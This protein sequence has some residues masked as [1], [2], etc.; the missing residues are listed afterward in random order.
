[1]TRR[2]TDPLPKARNAYSC[3]PPVGMNDP[4]E[5]FCYVDDLL[6]IHKYLTRKVKERGILDNAHHLDILVWRTETVLQEYFNADYLEC[7]D[8]DKGDKEH[9]HY[10]EAHQ[11][12]VEIF[13]S[14]WGVLPSKEIDDYR[15][16]KNM[17]VSL[18]SDFV[19]EAI[20]GLQQHEPSE[21]DFSLGVRPDTHTTSKNEPTYPF[22]VSS[23]REL[24]AEFGTE[25]GTKDDEGRIWLDCLGPL[26]K[27][28]HGV[29][30]LVG[31]VTG[32][33]VYVYANHLPIEGPGWPIKW[34]TE[35]ELSELY[36]ER[37][38]DE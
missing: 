27:L 38:R 23:V 25:V 14:L 6:Y 20:F 8:E 9:S 16:L 34:F 18:S 36:D 17:P 12:C 37:D 31:W 15:V 29:D 26:K 5:A 35:N 32:G 21:Y 24:Y 13:H 2:I 33:E 10:K 11:R 19:E 28:T 3:T 22:W 7:W 30:D 4:N 1:M